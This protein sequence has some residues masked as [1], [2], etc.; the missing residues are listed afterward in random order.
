MQWTPLELGRILGS[1]PHSSG[2]PPP[3]ALQVYSLILCQKHN[4][5]VKGISVQLVPIEKKRFGVD[6]P[7][8]AGA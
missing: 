3:T 7:V 4:E 5:L 2:S 1:L 6:R 8:A